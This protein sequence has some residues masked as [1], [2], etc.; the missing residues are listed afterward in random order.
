MKH[1]TQQQQVIDL[2]ESNH[3]ISSA[4]VAA[5]LKVNAETAEE[6]CNHA[7]AVQCRHWFFIRNFGKSELQLLED[8]V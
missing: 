6:L 3:K 4:F 8:G 5:K 1:T 2:L 7:W